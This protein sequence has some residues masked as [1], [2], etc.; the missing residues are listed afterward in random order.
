MSKTKRTIL[1][2]GDLAL[3][4]FSLLFA[5]TARNARIPSLFN[6]R[7]HLIPFSV[8]FL[9]WLLV[10]YAHR[11]Y[12]ASLFNQEISYFESLT[13]SFFLNTTLGLAWFY[14]LPYMPLIE[15]VVAPKTVLI[16]TSIAAIT[17]VHVWRN[18]FFP[19]FGEG[20]TSSVLLLGKDIKEQTRAFCE[21]SPFLNF[22]TKTTPKEEIFK[23]SDQVVFSKSKEEKEKLL[24]KI[25]EGLL[26][27]KQIQTQAEF[28]ESTAQKFPYFL[29]DES[30]ILAELSSTP[31]RIYDLTKRLADLTVA[32]ILGLLFSPLFL[33]IALFIKLEDR[34]PIFYTQPRIGR[35]Q[36]EFSLYKFRTMSPGEENENITIIGKFLRITHLDELP[37]IINIIKGDMAFVGPRPEQPHLVEKYQAAESSYKLRHLVKP[38]LTG[39]AQ[40]H[41]LYGDTVEKNLKKLEYDL[42]Y[43]KHRSFA[44]DLAITLKTASI[45][46]GTKGQ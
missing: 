30:E 4:Y 3:L 18:I 21:Q 23:N 22:T 45:V 14:L 32:L 37:Q 2:L 28:Y 43:I 35:Y 31:K 41:Y 36:K 1:L 19:L 20:R 33:P 46:L 27:Q 44:F 29:K 25:P 11:F 15:T 16:L 17:F 9:I 34:G 10:F 5:L 13:K 8:A 42:Y 12:D 38:G 6:F 40:I 24:Q 26:N 39:W 7:R